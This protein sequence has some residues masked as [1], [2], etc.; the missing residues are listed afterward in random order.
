MIL[1]DVP[2]GVVKVVFA[3]PDV[4]CTVVIGLVLGLFEITLTILVAVE[5]FPAESTAV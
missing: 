5:T 1:V 4:G 2:A 3:D